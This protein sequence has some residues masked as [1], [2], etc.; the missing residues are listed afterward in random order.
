[1]DGKLDLAGLM[2]SLPDPPELL[3]SVRSIHQ[4]LTPHQEYATREWL[5]RCEAVRLEA[6]GRV[7]VAAI[8]GGCETS[9]VLRALG[10]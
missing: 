1:M 5:I 7:L 6:M 3:R 10:G 2:D 9:A 8:R 4:R